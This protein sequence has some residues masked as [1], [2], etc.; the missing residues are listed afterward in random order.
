MN[1]KV[2]LIVLAVALVV[3]G[4][5]LASRRPSRPPVTVTLRVTVNPAERS[6]YVMGEANSAKFKYL[7]GKKS[8]LKPVLAQKLAVKAVANSPLLEAHIGVS[9]K[10]EAQQ[11]AAAFIETLQDLCGNQAQVALADQAVR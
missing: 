10:Q 5:V 11:Y 2:L 9:T 8:G 4:I 7:M 6:A 1:T 3:G